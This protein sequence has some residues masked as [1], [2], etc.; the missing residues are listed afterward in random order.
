MKAK[1]TIKIEELRDEQNPAYLFS[2]TG[3]DLLIKACTGQIDLKH[4]ALTELANRG[5]SAKTGRW[6]GFKAAKK[7][8]GL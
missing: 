3:N 1:K 8:L 4:L 5:L 6:I 7:E 2:I